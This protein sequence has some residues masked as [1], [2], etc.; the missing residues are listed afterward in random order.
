L[1]RRVASTLNVTLKSFERTRRPKIAGR[2]H[3][4]GLHEWVEIFRDRWGVPHI[5]AHNLHDLF[6][7]QGFVHAQ[8][9]LWQMDFQRRVVLDALPRC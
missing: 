6:F 1:N 2:L 4:D 7:A 8:D 3:L 9:R 5:Y